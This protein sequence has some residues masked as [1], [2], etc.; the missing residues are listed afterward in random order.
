M[1]FCRQSHGVEKVID[2][3]RKR[4]RGEAVELLTLLPIEIFPK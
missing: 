2:R 3:I 1:D 4:L